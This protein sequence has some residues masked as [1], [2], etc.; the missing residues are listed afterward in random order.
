MGKIRKGSNSSKRLDN[1]ID[2]SAPD[3]PGSDLVATT[4]KIRTADKQW[5]EATEESQSYHV[6]QA[7]SGYVAE[8]SLLQQIAKKLGVLPGE[9]IAR[10]IRA[11]GSTPF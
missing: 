2:N 6:R 11:Y 7:L 3:K 9:A 8:Y 10:A 4:V 1:L 5:L